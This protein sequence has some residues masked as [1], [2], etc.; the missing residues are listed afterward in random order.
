MGGFTYPNLEHL[1]AFIALAVEHRAFSAGRVETA[2]HAFWQTTY[3]K[4]QLDE[5]WLGTLLSHTETSL[6]SQSDEK[7]PGAGQALTPAVDEPRVDWGDAPAVTTFYGRA[8]EQ[9]LLT[10]WIVEE[11][12]RVVS[13]LGLGGI[14]KSALVARVM[15]QIAEHFEVVIWRF[16]RDALTC[17][18][19]L[20]EC[21]QVLAPQALQDLSGSLEG[22]L[23]LLQ[24]SLRRTRVLLVLDNLEVLLEEGQGT[25]HV[26]PGYE[27]Y[28]RLLLQIAETGH[29]SCLLLTSREK[30]SALAHQEGS[31]APVRALRLA[32]L[33]VHACE[34]LLAEK[35]V[36]GTSSEQARLIESYAGNP[37]ALKIVAQTIVDLFGGQLAP[38]LSQGEVIFGGVR[39][40]LAHQF[41]RLSA[42][43]QTL[44]LWLAVLR[45]PVSLEHLLALLITPLSRAQILEAIEALHRRS[46]IESGNMPASF[47]LQSVV[48]EYAT[49]HLIAEAASEIKHGQLARLLEHGLELATVKE[50]VRQTQ[51]RLLV[52]PLLVQVQAGSAGRGAV[53]ERLLALLDE[54]RSQAEEAQG[55][56]PAN[57]LALLRELRG[58]LRSL[59]LSHLTIR[60]AS[61][62]R[63][64]MQDASLSEATLQDTTFTE[65][66]DAV[67]AVAISSNGRYWAAGS[68]RGNVRVWQQGGK[69]LHRAWQAHT[70]TVSTLAFS[71]DGSTLATGSWDG[72]IKLWDI[73]SGDLL[74]TSWQTNNIQTL[75][76]AP[77]G[78]LLASGGNDA[79]IQLWD[80]HRGTHYQMLPNQGS[81]VY[82]LAWSPDGNLL[83]SGGLDGSIQLWELWGT[84]GAQPGTN[85]RVLTGHTDWVFALAF[86]PDG[87]T[88]ASG[89]F[90]RTVRLWDV[91]SLRVR[92]TLT[93]H[94]DKVRAIAWSPD[95]RM[96]ASGGMDRTIWLWSIERDS[97]CMML[98]G[99][100]AAVHALAFTPDSSNLLSGSD[101]GTLR[102]WEAASGQ[103]IHILQGYAVSL[104]DIAWSPDGTRLASAGSDMLNHM[105][106]GGPDATQAAAWS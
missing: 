83:A 61:L 9:K 69:L 106:S 88:L 46:L 55:Y 36:T 86:A 33:D 19:L 100:T 66:I 26:R 17:E 24:E 95:G 45:E 13:V 20:D 80:A 12:C 63:V 57:L 25:G 82:A 10:S 14:G 47:T 32:R 99:H 75:A 103:C 50:Y 72:S 73:A 1:K 23:S 91:E 51:W 76:F 38:F 27:G 58:H 98:Q 4:V 104:Y 40:L 56:G 35:E 84:Q 52:A 15:Y 5:S 71:P 89:S 34:L 93:G 67:R 8:W 42:V 54:L 48:L 85:V 21:L 49:A 101:D 29:Q 79:T 62:Q 43:E 102:V 78:H 11:R 96:L 39:E 87:R 70:R 74:W 81:A 105:G 6:A 77:D 18:A 3:Q 22:R 92:E 16:L 37:L 28:A 64:E 59:D 44:L 68:W 53:E 31:R 41:S 97:Y 65:A 7:T 90:D 2:I 30:F 94:I 60:G